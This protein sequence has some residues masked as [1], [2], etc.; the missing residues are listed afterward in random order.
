MGTYISVTGGKVRGQGSAGWRR[1]PEGIL[2]T[3]VAGRWTRGM[4]MESMKIK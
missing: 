3:Q 2:S 4:D 1:P